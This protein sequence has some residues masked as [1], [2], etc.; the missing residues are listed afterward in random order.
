MGYFFNHR[1]K[2]LH[3]TKFHSINAGL[4]GELQRRVPHQP[5]VNAVL[6]YCNGCAMDLG[7]TLIKLRPKMLRFALSLT[8]DQNLAEDL[9]QDVIERIIRQPENFKQHNAKDGYA[10]LSVK[11]RFIDD[12]RYKLRMVT[13]S[14]L[15]EENFFDGIADERAEMETT[16]GLERRDL[17]RALD[18]TGKDCLKIL[19]L[20]GVGRSYKEIS[21]QLGMAAGTVM[22][23][24][25]RCRSKLKIQ[26]E[27]TA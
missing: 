5:S 7:K 21:E 18:A 24:M 1:S 11:R 23:R 27:K 9:V 3:W 20:F 6:S 17:A 25:A 12:Q 16:S 22:S 8:P 26:L 4:H 10:L 13:E 15:G 14:S 2:S 19:T